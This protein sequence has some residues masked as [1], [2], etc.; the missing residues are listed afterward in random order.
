[1]FSSMYVIAPASAMTVSPGSSSISTSCNSP[2]K[3]SK[4]I[5][6]LVRGV[7]RGFAIDFVDGVGAG[8]AA[9]AISGN[10]G[11]PDDAGA[12][13]VTTAWHAG[14]RTFLPIKLSCTWSGRRH[15][16]QSMLNVMEHPEDG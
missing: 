1:M 8:S 6:W 14:Q 9:Y 16:W 10:G 3:I 12:G 5:S 13:T 2:P 4:S 7:A 11:G 15:D